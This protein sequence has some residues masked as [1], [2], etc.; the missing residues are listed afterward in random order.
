M[1][2][3]TRSAALAAEIAAMDRIERAMEAL[4][5]LPG[6]AQARVRRWVAETY[7]VPDGL[8]AASNGGGA[9]RPSEEEQ[10]V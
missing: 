9:G 2:G 1:P 10:R 6:A 5:G 4:D 3:H 8:P 7:P